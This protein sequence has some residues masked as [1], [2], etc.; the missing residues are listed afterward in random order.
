MGRSVIVGD[1]TGMAI[2]NEDDDGEVVGLGGPAVAAGDSGDLASA[3]H[4]ACVKA[5][6][7]AAITIPR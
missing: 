3:P 6:S 4:A 7:N 2:G 1:G 5:T